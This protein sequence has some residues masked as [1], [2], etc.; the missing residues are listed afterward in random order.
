[1]NVPVNCVVGRIVYLYPPEDSLDP[2]ISGVAV[3]DSGEFMG[4]R[5]QFDRDVCTAFG[6]SLHRADLGHLFSYGKIS[7]FML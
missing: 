6:H 7:K 2:V 5:V 3:L 4:Q 1:M